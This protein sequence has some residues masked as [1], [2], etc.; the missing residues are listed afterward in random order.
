LIRD[1]PGAAEVVETVIREARAVVS[2]L[3][4]RIR[5]A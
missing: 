3:S 4:V 5:Q 1:L 2:A